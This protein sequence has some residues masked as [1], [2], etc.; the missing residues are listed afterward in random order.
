MFADPHGYCGTPYPL[1]RA[2]RSVLAPLPAAEDGAF[3][4]EMN[5]HVDALCFSKT[6]ANCDV[7]LRCPKFFPAAFAS[8]ELDC[9]QGQNCTFPTSILE[10][11]LPSGFSSARD[12]SFYI[13]STTTTPAAYTQVTCRADGA[14][15]SDS[16]PG[17]Y[18]VCDTTGFATL[19]SVRQYVCPSGYRLRGS[20][21]VCILE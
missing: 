20:G 16:S 1:S 8:G 3:T 7:T 5:S 11:V 15:K 6:Q 2:A 18:F 19:E 21:P 12:K 14:T 13:Q 10:C 17:K 4:S 9:A